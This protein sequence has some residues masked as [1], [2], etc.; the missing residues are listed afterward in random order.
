M[1]T[2]HSLQLEDYLAAAHHQTINSSFYSPHPFYPYFSNFKFLNYC[3]PHSVDHPNFLFFCIKAYWQL[4]QT[5][6]PKESNSPA[7]PIVLYTPIKTNPSSTFFPPHFFH[8]FFL[9]LEKIVH[10]YVKIVL[11]MHNLLNSGESFQSLL[12]FFSYF[13]QFLLLLLVIALTMLHH[14]FQVSCFSSLL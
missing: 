8:F 13:N 2:I 9:G 11:L 1:L 6:L 5:Q 3:C 12:F 4:L 7:L 10:L 14:S